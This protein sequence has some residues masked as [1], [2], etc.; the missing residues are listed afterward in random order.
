MPDQLTRDMLDRYLDGD[1]SDAER[2]AFELRLER[3]PAL[4][5]AVDRQ[6]QID[7]ALR[8]QFAAPLMRAIAIAALARHADSSSVP[9]PLHIEGPSAAE[10]AP[11]PAGRIEP[12]QPKPQANPWL[13]R[14]AVA[15]VLAAGLFGAWQTWTYLKPSDDHR[16]APLQLV[17]AAQYYDQKVAEGFEPLWVCDDDEEFAH[18]FR[19]RL[20]QPLLLKPAP[21]SDIR[22]LGL[23]YTRV[24]SASTISMLGEAGGQQVIVLVDRAAD[25]NPQQISSGCGSSNLHTFRREI[26]NLVIYEVTPLDQPHLMDLLYQP[27]R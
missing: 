9:E 3:E 2:H 5:K 24:L 7:G 16:A 20:G 10:A 23:D 21:S 18:T 14:L 4:R 26:G 6:R 17:T 25:D 19:Y 1:L 8:R 22:M 27:E 11:A 13:R 15:A 12:S